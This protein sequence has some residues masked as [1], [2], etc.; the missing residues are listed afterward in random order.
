DAARE[1]YWASLEALKI[2]GLPIEAMPTDAPAIVSLADALRAAPDF[3]LLR[4]TRKSV[5]DFLAAYDLS[6]LA[7]GLDL[8]FLPSQRPMLIVRERAKHGEAGAVLSIYDEYLR[9]RLEFAIKQDDAEN[10]P[11]ARLRLLR[12]GELEANSVLRESD[13]LEHELIF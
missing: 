1:A 13:L 12:A 9:R 3:V 10:G 4:T 5:A 2:H 6:R 8:G 11:R 7:F